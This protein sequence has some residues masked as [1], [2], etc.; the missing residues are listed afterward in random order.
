MKTLGL[1]QQEWAGLENG[2]LHN[3]DGTL[4]QGNGWNEG[5]P[6]EWRL[7]GIGEDQVTSYLNDMKRDLHKDGVTFTEGQLSYIKNGLTD[8]W[9]HHESYSDGEWSCIYNFNIT[10]IRSN[11]RTDLIIQTML[12]NGVK[13]KTIGKWIKT[14]KQELT[15]FVEFLNK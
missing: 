3:E 7:Y 1:T 13:R 15:F 9:Q 4:K 5:R 14:V 8:N 11:T 12:S 6:L 2:P 10:Q